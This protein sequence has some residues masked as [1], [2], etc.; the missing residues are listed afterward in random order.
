MST[1]VIDPPK[2]KKRPN[3]N[4]TPN[5]IP[6]S[7]PGRSGA[8]TIVATGPLKDILDEEIH[9]LDA[10]TIV[11]DSRAN[12][13]DV[14]GLSVLC[15]RAAGLLPDQSFEAVIRRVYDI[16]TGKSRTCATELADALLLACDRQIEDE[17]T[18]ATLPGGKEA[19]LEMATIAFEEGDEPFT[20]LDVRRLAKSL[21]GFARGYVADTLCEE[22]LDDEEWAKR[23]AG[24]RLREAAKRGGH[25]FQKRYDLERHNW[26]RPA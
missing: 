25:P 9:R 6:A 23:V 26:E 16:R 12:G 2:K 21:I 13:D 8:D 4:V 24:Y 15:H 7:T 20:Q 14:G 18:I 17:P 11:M 3:G 1:A 19:A 10:T 22:Q 5:G